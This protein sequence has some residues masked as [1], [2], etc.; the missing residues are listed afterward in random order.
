MIKYAKLGLVKNEATT[1]TAED[2]EMSAIKNCCGNMLPIRGGFSN[3]SQ[4]EEVIVSGK[5]LDETGQPIPMAHIINKTRSM[6]TTTDNNGVYSF[7]AGTMDDIEVSSVGFKTMKMKAGG[8]GKK[9]QLQPST[10]QL[11]EVVVTAKQMCPLLC[12]LKKNK[13]VIFIGLGVATVLVTIWGINNAK[14]RKIH[15]R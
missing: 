13:D 2:I 1:Y 6:G 12:F 7:R 10:T 4:G 5:L 9:L 8:I 3:T 14:K 15:V 11:P